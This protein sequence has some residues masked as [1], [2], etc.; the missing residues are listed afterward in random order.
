MPTAI[1][2]PGVVVMPFATVS[3][4]SRIG[5]CTFIMPNVW[6]GL[7]TNIG[8]YNFLAAHACIGSW[9]KTGTGV[10]IAFNSTVTG[11]LNLHNY[12]ALGASSILTKDIPAEEVWVG[13]PAKFHKKVSEK[14]RF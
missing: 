5:K 6:I 10:W 12:C 13:N 8:N 9:V 7:T 4:N 3:A 14:I 1:L 11:R 2:E